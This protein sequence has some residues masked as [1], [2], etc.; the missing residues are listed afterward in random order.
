MHLQGCKFQKRKAKFQHTVDFLDFGFWFL[1]FGPYT[2]CMR[3]LLIGNYG[4]SNIGDEAL[5]EYFVSTFTEVHWTV[6]GTDVPRLPFGFRSFFRLWPKTIVAI[7]R[8][9]MIVFGGGS[10]FTDSE[11]VVACVLWWWH[12]IVAC[13]FQKRLVLAFQGVGP[14]RT[15]FGE[16]LAKWI[17]TH[18]TFISVRDEASH[19]RIQGWKLRCTPLLT[20]DPAFS[21]FAERKPM[22]NA[23]RILGIIPRQ[24]SDDQFFVEVSSAVKKPFDEVRILLMQP[25]ESERSIAEKI[26]AMTGGTASIVPITSVHQLLTEISGAREILTQR[27]HGVLA[28]LAIGIPV[29]IVP[30]TKGDKLDELKALQNDSKRLGECLMLVKRG[31]EGMR[32]VL[33]CLA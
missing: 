17:F 3:C 22:Q 4:V 20:F 9:D 33:Q 11:S 25:D 13:L 28:A 14:F 18:A 10:L 29:R 7:A 30:Q 15:V 5:R 16:L 12:G 21:V 31:E 8:A 6:L 26:R 19:R 32:R 2:Y 27:Y 23:K 1:E 24:N